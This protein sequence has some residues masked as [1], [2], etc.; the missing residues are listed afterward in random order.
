MAF[1]NACLPESNMAATAILNLI[2]LI[3]FFQFLPN[4]TEFGINVESLKAN[5]CMLSKKYLVARIQ[6]GSCRYLEFRKTNA[7]SSV[8]DQMSSNLLGMLRL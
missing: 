3:A 1:K 8:F 4:F 2:K 6:D 7:V 5:T